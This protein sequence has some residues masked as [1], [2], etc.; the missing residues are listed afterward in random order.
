MGKIVNQSEL[1]E[2]LNV[3]DRTIWRWQKDGMPVKS[4]GSNGACNEYDTRVVID[5]MV[6]REINRRVVNGEDG[7][8]YDLDGE[9]A[10]LT[11]HQANIA[12]LDEQVREGKLIPADVVENRWIGFVLAFKA[13]VRS[14]PVKSAH[15]FISLTDLNQIQDCLIKNLDEALA[16]L[17]DY[18]PEHYGIKPA[19]QGSKRGKTSA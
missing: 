9:R 18:D 10:R 19:S 4:T 12:S 6:Q 3:S 1:I 11:Y 15:Q 17:A 7:Q 2:I 16:E 13:K 14:I 5:W 8:R